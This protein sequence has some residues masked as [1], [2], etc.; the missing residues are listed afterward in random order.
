M[1]LPRVLTCLLIIA[2]V[3]LSSS[4]PGAEA[5]SEAAK[6]R[7]AKAGLAFVKAVLTMLFPPPTPAAKFYSADFSDQTVAG[8][9]SIAVPSKSATKPSQFRLT[10]AGSPYPPQEVTLN[11]RSPVVLGSLGKN[12]QCSQVAPSVWDC[13]GQT[14]LTQADI[15]NIGFTAGVGVR[16]NSYALSLTY[17]DARNMGLMVDSNANLAVAKA[18]SKMEQVFGKTDLLAGVAAGR[19]QAAINSEKLKGG[20]MFAVSNINRKCKLDV[21]IVVVSPDAPKPSATISVTDPATADT[22]DLSLPCAW[23]QPRPGVWLCEWLDN[24]PSVSGAAGTAN[25]AYAAASSMRAA[26]LP[27]SAVDSVFKLTVESEA[28]DTAEGTLRYTL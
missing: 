16:V 9:F 3:L 12:M 19:F 4:L 21:S 23:S 27:G 20:A 6:Q 15:N 2:G 10:A 13:F 17:T 11:A 1:A 25:A 24:F 28:G 5:L 8:T 22:T 14:K 7:A 26:A 18:N